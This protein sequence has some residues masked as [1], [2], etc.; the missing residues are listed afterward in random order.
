M[1]GAISIHSWLRWRSSRS[2]VG[3]CSGFNN[4]LPRFLAVLLLWIQSFAQPASSQSATDPMA[5]HFRAAQ[6]SL[7]AGD[8]DTATVEYKAFLSEA[9]HRA[10]NARAHAGDL[11]GATQ[12]FEEA[13][14]F[15]DAENKSAVRLDYASVLFDQGRFK[16]AESTAE[17]VTAQD[18]GNFRTHLLLGKILFEE[19]DYAGAIA[20]LQAA[21]DHGEFREAWRPLALAYLRQ[22]RLEPGRAVLKKTLAQLGN[23]PSNRVTAATIYYYGDYPDQAAAELKTVL[24]QHPT[25]PDAHYYLGLAYLARNEE[26]DYTR[27]VPE[28]RTELKIAPN[29]FRSHYMLGY[30]ALQQRHFAEAE[31]ELLRA[32]AINLQDPGTQLL[33]G[34]LYSQTD[35]SKQAIIVLR[36]LIA[37]WGAAPTDFL[38]ARAHYI[39]G[40]A[41]REAGNFDEGA[42]EI[43]TAEK[44]RKELRST[45]TESDESRLKRPAGADGGEAIGNDK[46]VTPPSSAEQGLARGFLAQISPLIGEAYYNLAGIA[47]Q[48]KDSTTATHYLK[49]SVEW[50]PSLAQAQ[51]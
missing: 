27:A 34:Q 25:T 16:D 3:G 28:F 49:I 6:Q 51:H 14:T 12:A 36:A 19:K 50:D 23:T 20:P 37:I 5:Q 10:A 35:R 42:S 9:I 40:R 32:R 33:L 15:T 29:D 4:G 1:E 31:P 24:A 41:L 22:R 21:A 26:A 43:N 17:Q 13:L 2:G 11:S 30:I 44:L 46:R 48:H 38:L 7:R 47:A 8:H 45:T 39:L 18:P